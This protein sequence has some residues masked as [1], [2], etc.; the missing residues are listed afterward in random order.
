MV[1][2]EALLD[3]LYRKAWYCL[4]SGIFGGF[5]VF[6]LRLFMAPSHSWVAFCG[7][8]FKCVKQLAEKI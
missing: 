3:D 6:C 1:A 8:T 4:M 2:L 7:C 5:I